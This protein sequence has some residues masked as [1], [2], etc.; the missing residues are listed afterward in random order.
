MRLRAEYGVAHLNGTDGLLR[1]VYDFYRGHAERYPPAFRIRI[2]PP[3]GPGT[4]PLMRTRFSSGRVSTTV[5]PFT[6]TRLLPICPGSAL[7][8]NTREGYELH[9]MDPGAR[10]NMEP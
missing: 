5:N 7:F 2:N 9:P 6:V 8:F 1:L 4:A 10:W 3:T